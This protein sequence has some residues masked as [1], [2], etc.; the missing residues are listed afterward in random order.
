[1]PSPNR[2]S[3][4]MQPSVDIEE[5]SRLTQSG[6]FGTL[7]MLR[8]NGGLHVSGSSTMQR[9]PARSLERATV[10]YKAPIVYY[11]LSTSDPVPSC[12]VE[13]AESYE[14]GEEYGAEGVCPVVSPETLAYL[15][16]ELVA[17]DKVCVVHTHRSMITVIVSIVMVRVTT[18][19][20]AI[21][22]WEQYLHIRK[23]GFETL[24][25]L[26]NQK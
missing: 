13:D 17:L 14:V 12:N 18:M 16:D 4:C 5:R 21:V 26:R 22:A 2:P 10:P 15:E 25:T 11:R 24:R 8:Q 20:G 7:R 9:T 19:G 6:L 1:M 23:A 3:K